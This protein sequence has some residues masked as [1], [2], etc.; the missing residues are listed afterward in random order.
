MVFAG[1]LS[2]AWKNWIQ[3]YNVYMT[4]TGN[5]HLDDDQQIA[6]LL[7][8]LGEEAIHIYNTFPETDSVKEV[9]KLFEAY[10][11]RKETVI[12]ERFKFFNAKQK[13]NQSVDNYILELQTLSSTCAFFERDNMCRDKLIIGLMDVGLQERLLKMD[14]LDLDTAADFC[15]SFEASQQQALIARNLLKS[16]VDDNTAENFGMLEAKKREHLSLFRSEYQ[17]KVSK[18]KI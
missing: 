10:C 7:N 14:P 13:P 5:N 15:R 8:L 11:N 2:V 6:I 4:A 9:I 16:S 18:K 12:Q 17:N 3:R 1:N